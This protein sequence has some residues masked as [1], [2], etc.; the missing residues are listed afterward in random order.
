MASMFSLAGVVFTFFI[1]WSGTIAQERSAKEL[2]PPPGEKQVIADP[3]VLG[4]WLPVKAYD[5]NEAVKWGVDFMLSPSG[6]KDRI[7][8]YA[9]DLSEVD[10]E[11]FRKLKE[12]LIN[13]QPKI[14]IIASLPSRK[15]VFLGRENGYFGVPI[16]L[17]GSNKPILKS[18]ISTIAETEKARQFVPAI[19]AVSAL[20]TSGLDVDKINT[21]KQLTFEQ[22]W[23][24]LV[25]TSIKI[26]GS[27]KPTPYIASLTGWDISKNPPE[28]MATLSELEQLL[29]Y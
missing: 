10:A 7:I 3:F 9:Y 8:L 11:F 26:A 27:Y 6:A 19:I 4:P 17:D 2:S 29:G 12:Q 23:S 28:T 24:G 18:F 20:K 1:F 13:K 25:A 14:A 16:I 15:I 5:G 21:W 22:P